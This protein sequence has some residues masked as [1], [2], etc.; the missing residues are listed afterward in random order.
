MQHIE[1]RGA[2]RCQ[3]PRP[4]Q[5]VGE[6]IGALEGKWLTMDPVVLVLIEGFSASRGDRGNTHHRFF[7]VSKSA[8]KLDV[9]ARHATQIR[10]IIL[11]D[12]QVSVNFSRADYGT[13]RR[14]EDCEFVGRR[15]DARIRNV[16]P[17]SAPAR[18]SQDLQDS[19]RSGPGTLPDSCTTRSDRLRVTKSLSR[20]SLH[21][22]KARPPELP[23]RF[24][25]TCSLS[26]P[27]QS[28]G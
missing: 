28:P 25:L 1:F 24:D 21:P 20:R 12:E 18:A 11:G 9:S 3:P 16:D 14:R 13:L 2:I 15:C 17:V 4:P 6:S 5:L 8:T 22:D 10:P 26:P 27:A 19:T 7:A 23:S